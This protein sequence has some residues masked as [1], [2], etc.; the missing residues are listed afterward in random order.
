MAIVLVSLVAGCASGGRGGELD[1]RPS[2]QAALD[3]FLQSVKNHDLAVMS[4]VW[5]GPKGAAGSYIERGELE[6]REMIIQCHMQHDAV[7][8]TGDY[9]GEGGRRVFRLDLTKS[10]VTKS[11]SV[12]TVEGPGSRWYVESADIE[13]T[14]SFCREG[15]GSG[16]A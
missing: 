1:G 15:L 7:K 9:A 8:V 11:T 16:S 13:K 14:V 10:G 12:T 4:R 2:P 3:A 6:K 5:G